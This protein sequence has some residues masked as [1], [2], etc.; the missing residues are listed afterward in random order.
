MSEGAHVP[1]RVGY[2]P[3]PAI[4]LY[5]VLKHTARGIQKIECATRV[6][7]VAES[8]VLEFNQGRGPRDFC[9]YGW[10]EVELR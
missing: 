10:V 7:A 8:L 9:W 1:P 6:K 3:Q 4:K 2:S 5:A